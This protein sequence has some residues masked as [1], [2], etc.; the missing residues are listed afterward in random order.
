M[1]GPEHYREAERLLGEVRKGYEDGPT[2]SYQHE[3][4]TLAEAQ[5][6]ATLALAAATVEAADEGRP[7]S[8][9][10]PFPGDDVD[11]PLP[12]N[13]WGRAFYGSLDDCTDSAGCTSGSHIIG[14]PAG[15]AR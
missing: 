10:R 13:G 14:C 6:H 15:S 4:C 2:M 8:V 1:N 12:G 11:P 3:S 7:V 9:L 5:V